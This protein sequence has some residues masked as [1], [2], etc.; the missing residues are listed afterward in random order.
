M[1][2]KLSTITPATSKVVV[3]NHPPVMASMAVLENEGTIAEG[4]IVAKDDDGKLIAHEKVT[5]AAMTGTVDGTNDDFTATL[6]PIPVLPGSVRID[7]NNTSAQVLVDDGCGN[8]TGHGT[9]TVNYGTGAVT[10]ALT[11]APASGKTVLS[12]HKTKP[13]GVIAEA[14]DTAADDTALVLRHGTV[15]AD[16][17]LR[18]SAAPDAEDLAALNAIGIHA[19]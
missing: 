10:V 14:C 4:Q 16:L 7:N 2:A 5:A 11:T 6:A 13:V 19:V 3:A 12:S 18:G 17:L 9:G 15:K 1:N 8:L